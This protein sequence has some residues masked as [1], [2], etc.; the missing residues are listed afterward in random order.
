MLVTILDVATRAEVTTSMVARVKART[1]LMT[2]C[3][4]SSYVPWNA[5]GWQG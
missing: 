5:K 2:S 4:M 3:L 1:M